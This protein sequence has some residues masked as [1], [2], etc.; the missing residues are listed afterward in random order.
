MCS[1]PR[2]SAGACAVGVRA[3]RASSHAGMGELPDTPSAGSPGTS[4][5]LGS[6]LINLI[7]LQ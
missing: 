3:V 1:Q 7:S 4:P 6:L 5:C 2:V